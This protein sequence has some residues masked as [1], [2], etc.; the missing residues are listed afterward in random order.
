MTVRARHDRLARIS[1]RAARRDSIVRPDDIL[2]TRAR[3]IN[4]SSGENVL[5]ALGGA[6]HGARLNLLSLTYDGGTLRIG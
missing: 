2:E 4:F 3:G 1:S 6:V 5:S